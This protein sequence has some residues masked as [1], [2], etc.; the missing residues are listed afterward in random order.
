[1]STS[2][3]ELSPV[4]EGSRERELWIQHA[5]GFILWED[6]RGYARERLPA[7]LDS[8]CRAVAETAID[9]AIY[10]LMIVIDGVTGGLATC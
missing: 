9:D 1:M 6:V 7:T 5:A 2:R 10:G 3:F 8:G 4:P